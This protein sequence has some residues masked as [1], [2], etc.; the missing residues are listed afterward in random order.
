MMGTRKDKL[1]QQQ[2]TISVTRVAKQSHTRFTDLTH[3]SGTID[4]PLT[5]TSL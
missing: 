4:P 1:Y 2:V 3:T 5:A